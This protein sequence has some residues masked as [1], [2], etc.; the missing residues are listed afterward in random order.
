[1]TADAVVPEVPSPAGR[2][3]RGGRG[4]AW[5]AAGTDARSWT[6][7]APRHRRF[8][9]AAPTVLRPGGVLV[10]VHSGLCGS[11]ATLQRLAHAGVR[12]S[13]TDR[14]EVPHGPVLRS[15]RPWLIQEGLLDCADKG[16][17]LVVI[18]AEQA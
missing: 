17:E 13:I 18:R 14:A 6:G 4:P 3:P 16:E 15:R 8:C 7:S 12:P 10:I 2:L 9:A 5:Q 11:Q 1:M